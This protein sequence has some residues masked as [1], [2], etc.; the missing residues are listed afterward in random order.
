MFGQ[1]DLSILERSLGALGREY[2]QFILIMQE[3]AAAFDML[4]D[5]AKKAAFAKL[6]SSIE[7][8]QQQQA[9]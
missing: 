8:N 5:E 2:I 1:L 7:Q 4:D 9:K 3:K 6:K